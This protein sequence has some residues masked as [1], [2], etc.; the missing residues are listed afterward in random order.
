MKLLLKNYLLFPILLKKF[1]FKFKLLFE[2]VLLLNYFLFV[3]NLNIYDL[4]FYYL[5]KVLIIN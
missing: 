2:F 3:E 1:K 4:L 5:V